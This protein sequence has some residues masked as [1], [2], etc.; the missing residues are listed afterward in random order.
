MTASDPLAVI[1]ASISDRLLVPE[2]AIYPAVSLDA[3]IQIYDILRHQ[4]A[5]DDD[6]GLLEAAMRGRCGSPVWRA[7]SAFSMAFSPLGLSAD[8]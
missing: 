5:L 2:A 6:A 3:Q 4:L 1:P 8:S 7:I